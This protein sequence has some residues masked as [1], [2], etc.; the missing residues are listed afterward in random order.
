MARY[1][2]QRTCA[3]A[4]RPNKGVKQAGFL[5]LRETSM[6]SCLIELGFIT[7]PE[8]ERFLNTENGIDALGRGIYNAFLDYRK[9]YD[10]SITVPYMSEAQKKAA[11]AEEDKK[12]E[13][14]KSKSKK[15]NTDAENIV[16][17]LRDARGGRLSDDL[18]TAGGSEEK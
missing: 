11:E 3:A 4:G 13:K 8:E 15:K 9:K 6:P 17:E 10:K 16:A 14:K 18:R 1:V 5:V 12:E 7:T 2:Q